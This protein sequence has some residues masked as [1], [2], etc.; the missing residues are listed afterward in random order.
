MV[1]ILSEIQ[2]FSDAHGYQKTT[3]VLSFM[4]LVTFLVLGEKSI[5][6]YV[7]SQFLLNDEF[8]NLCKMTILVNRVSAI[9]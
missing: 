7:F 5:V 4:R 6:T 3:R 8:F 1:L 9:F 2:E